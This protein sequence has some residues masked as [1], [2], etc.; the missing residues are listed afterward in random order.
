MNKKNGYRLCFV[1]SALF[2]V[3]FVVQVIRDYISY[4]DP[5]LLNSAPFY[6]WVIMDGLYFLLPGAIL[7]LVGQL[8]KKKVNKKR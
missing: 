6:L 7:F 4:L 3:V 5:T 2:A 1:G 8:L